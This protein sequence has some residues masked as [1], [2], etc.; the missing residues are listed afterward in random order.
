M[1]DCP[2]LTTANSQ[3]ESQLICKHPH[4]GCLSQFW[5]PESQDSVDFHLLSI[6]TR[7]LHVDAAMEVQSSL[8]NLKAAQSLTHS[9]NVSRWGQTSVQQTP[10]PA[11]C[12]AS[13]SY[14]ALISLYLKPLHLIFYFAVL[15]GV[16]LRVN[17]MLAKHF[18]V[19]KAKSK[20]N[21]LQPE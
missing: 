12:S 9:P 15:P 1:K 18:Q 10:L 20:G 19:I 21:Y 16:N 17:K 6:L 11:F 7:K 13:D 2:K 3:K 4:L 5:K 14:R 8:L